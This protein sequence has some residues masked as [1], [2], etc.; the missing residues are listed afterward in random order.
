M[1][2]PTSIL[3]ITTLFN[4]MSINW[5]LSSTVSPPPVPAPPRCPLLIRRLR[6]IIDLEANEEERVWLKRQSDGELDESRLTEGLTGEAAIY[7]RRG[8]EKRKFYARTW[9]VSAS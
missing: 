7:K 1:V 5:C 4:H 6:C 8:M 3:N 9:F 2:K